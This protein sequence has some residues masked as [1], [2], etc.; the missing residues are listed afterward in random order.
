VKGV[1]TIFEAAQG[2]WTKLDL[3]ALM[4]PLRDSSYDPTKTNIDD[5][6]ATIATK[7]NSQ[8]IEIILQHTSTILHGAIQTDVS[9]QQV[10]GTSL[11]TVENI[12]THAKLDNMSKVACIRDWYIKKVSEEAQASGFKHSLAYIYLYRGNQGIHFSDIVG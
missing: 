12:V 3:A 6:S 2:C 5:L 1:Y 7:L 11:V 10:N 9:T 4:G 8:N